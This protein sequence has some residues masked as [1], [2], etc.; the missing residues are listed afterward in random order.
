MKNQITPQLVEEKLES[1]LQKLSLSKPITVADIR[2]IIWNA[3]K[4]SNSSQ[5]F[6]LLAPHAKDQETI[7]EIMKII[8]DAWN[9]FPHRTL[10]GKSPN[11]LVMEHHQTGNIDQSKQI[12]LPKKGKSLQ[13]VFDDRY[14]KTVVFEKISDDTWG[15][16]FPKLYHDLTE[17]LWELEES[18]VSAQVFE[19]EL[20]RMI[21]LMP[22]LFDAVNALAHLYGKKREFGLAKTLY[23]QTISKAR[24]H[25]PNSFTQGKDQVI[26]AYMENRP[27]LRLLAGY[28]MY[29]EQFENIEKA[30][31]L[32]EE[33]LSFNRN[34]NQGIRTILITAYLQTNQPEKVIELTTHYPNDGMPDTVMGKLLA[35]VM[36]KRDAEA[37]KNLEQI[38]EYKAHI[39]KELLKKSHQRPATYREDMIAMGSPD[40]AYYYWQHQGKLWKEVP[41]AMD[42]L[43]E[44]TKDIQAHSISLTD[45]DVLTVDFF[46]DFLTFLTFLKERP[47]KRTATGNLSLKN[48][49]SLLQT[50]K[51][52]KPILDYHEQMR[53]KIKREDDILPLNLIKIMADIMKLTYK[54]HDKLLLSKN[55]KA[56]FDKLS[57]AEQ[58]TQLFHYYQQRL[59]WAYSTSLTKNQ[60]A[61]ARLLQVRQ[62]SIWRLLA[63]KKNEWVEY[64]T[65]CEE[66]RKE[67][68][69]EPFLEEAYSTPEE[70]LERRIE[71]ILFS[72][73]LAF[74]NCVE[75]ETKQVNNWDTIIIRFRLTKIGLTLLPEF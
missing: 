57:H 31:I 70:I 42:F 52:V 38:K 50:L 48:I 69:L 4:S 26:W 19:K 3:Q 40:E 37:K 21:K 59:N 56:F 72:R 62:D 66:L 47:I 46:H 8:Q 36:L 20:Y 11:D 23:E 29:V 54:K 67:L 75:L 71:T 74:F 2:D 41:G 55:G 64:K 17:E 12:L 7:Q 6:S 5:L 28:A 18:K 60:E 35:L 15:W 10:G 53:S 44:N 39:I 73:I 43:R 33:L 45:E 30:I 9:Y 25:I 49:E 16:G 65:F 68:P 24:T 32:Y 13:D 63:K 51:T 58:F 14:P 34:D 61:I 27:F 22:E 1:L